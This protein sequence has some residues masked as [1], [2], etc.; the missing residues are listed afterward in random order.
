M[1]VVFA[2]MG[3]NVVKCVQEGFVALEEGKDLTLEELKQFEINGKAS[4]VII[5]A[6]TDAEYAKVMDCKSAKEIWDRLQKVYEGDG[7]MKE[8]KLQ[9]FKERYESLRMQKNET[10]QE[11]F[12]MV[13]DAV[14]DL[15]SHG[16]NKKDSSIVKKILRILPERF[17]SKVAAIEESRDLNSMSLHDLQCN[18]IAYEMRIKSTESSSMSSIS[19]ETAF[20]AMRHLKIKEKEESSSEDNDD[21]EGESEGEVLAYFTRKL[22]KGSKKGKGQLSLRCY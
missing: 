16:K 13:I 19:K 6:L 3:M 12:T 5:S 4:N 17:A 10:I 15:R 9:V 22:K 2:T 8:A 1:Q 20:K 18:L 11:F 14:N 21:D 7:R